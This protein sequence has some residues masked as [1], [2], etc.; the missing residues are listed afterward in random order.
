MWGNGSKK[1]LFGIDSDTVYFSSCGRYPLPLSS[2]DAGE[3][4]LLK[5][6]KFPQNVSSSGNEK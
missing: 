4:E 5:K 6:A 1:S 2:V 3:K